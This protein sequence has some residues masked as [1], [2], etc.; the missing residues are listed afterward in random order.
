LRGYVSIQVYLA[1]HAGFCDGV[2][3]ALELTLHHVEMGKEVSTFG[4]LVHNEKVANVLAQ[5]GVKVFSKLDEIKSGTII[6]RTHGATPDIL[7]RLSREPNIEVIDA[8]CPYVKRLQ[9]IA[10]NFSVKGYT[11]LIYGNREHPEVQ[12]L[13][14][15]AGKG[16][17]VIAP[18]EYEGIHQLSIPGKAV[19]ISQTTQREKEFLNVAAM[20]KSTYA[21]LDTYKTI[22]KATVLRQNAAAKLASAVDLMLV[23]GDRK[24]SNTEKLA[25]VCREMIKTYQIT[26]AEEISSRWLVGIKK[27][28]VTA[29]ASTPDWTI[30]EVMDHMENENFEIRPEEESSPE[31]ENKQEEA[32]VQEESLQAE[33]SEQEESLQAEASEQEESLQVEA[34]EQVEAGEQEEA[35]GQE[36]ESVTAREATLEET[37][38]PAEGETEQEEE[39][40]NQE[41]SFPYQQDVKEYRP[42]DMVTGK[43]VLV[44]DDQLLVDIGWKSDAVLPKA[45][46]LLEGGSTLKDTFSE[47]DDVDVLVLKINE[48]EDKII[49]SQKRLAR[50]RRWKELNEALE[51]GKGMEGKVKDVVSAGIIV[52]LGSGIEGFMPGS[53]VDVRYIPDFQ[54]FLGQELSFKIIELNRE[55]DKVILSRKKLLEVEAEEQKQ[56]TISALEENAIINGVVKRLTDFGAF[57]DVGGIDGLVHISEVSWQR[58]GHPQEV[59]SVGEEIKVKVLEVIPE[60]ERISLSVRQAQPD[61][62]SQISEKF[63]EGDIVKG[64]VTRIVNFGAF[65]ELMPGVE[66]L[67]H[68]SQMADFHV[69]HPSE[70]IQE[71]E[72]V[73]A[74]ILEINTQGKRISLSVK[75]AR[76][77]PRDFSSHSNQPAESDNQGVTLGDVFGDLF[78]HEDYT[79]SQDEEK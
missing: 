35:A 69:K 77:A 55:R 14:G 60:R 36:E 29:G 15:W 30:K 58:V 24:S 20:L 70:I 7:E 51:S 78:N 4:P 39:A 1:E 8:T 41:E 3:N 23:V 16:A 2:K 67:V 12:A 62:W 72:E 43:V 21:E 50:E 27:V 45:E 76:P 13:L 22:C 61:P 46:I 75:E 19:L 38:D 6:I 37:A 40:M 33:A 52:N 5:K 53:L 47:G 54:T 18:G 63:S 31:E 9:K 10:H 65:V 71:G 49:V 59:L 57:V 74:K 48:Q 26:G 56:K 17:M 79:N 11:I 25:K 34:N 28:G 42:G 73:D 44:E 64:K 66:G 68:I 32:S